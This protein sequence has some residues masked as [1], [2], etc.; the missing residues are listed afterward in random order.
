[1]SLEVVEQRLSRKAAGRP[2]GPRRFDGELLD[3]HGA[4]AL[5][6]VTEKTIRARV[7]R[8]TVPFRRFGG[9]VVFLRKDIEAFINELPGCGLKEAQRNLVVRSGSEM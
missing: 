1:M 9:R 2:T 6:G 3:V 5:L 4:A 7:G 8:R